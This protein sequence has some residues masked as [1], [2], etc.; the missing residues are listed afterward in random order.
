MRG[1]EGMERDMTVGKPGKIILNFTIPIFI[2]NIFQQLYSMVDTVIVGKFVGNEALAAVGSCGTLMFLILGFLMGLTAGFTVVTAQ[3]FGAGNMRAMRQSVASASVLSAVIS[4]L[5]T[6]LSMSFMKQILHLMHTPEDIYGEAY[7]YIMIICGGIVA[8]VLYNLLASILRALGNSKI[9]L[10]FL[11]LAA[12]LNIVLDLV[13]IIVFHL[14]AAG[15]AWATVI[16]QGISGILCL[17][18]IIKAVPELYLK[19]EDWHMNWN[20]A[21]W[22]MKIGLPMAFQYS[23]TAI[24]TIMVQT[25]L[26]TLGSLAVASFAA[27]TKI[28]QVVTQAYGAMGTTMATYCAQNTGA[29]K[30]DRVRQGFRSATIMGSIYAVVT[31]AVLILGGKYLTILFVKDNLTQVMGMVDIYLRCVSIMFIP[32]L[33]VNVYRNGIQG[34]GFGLLPMMAGIAELIGRGVMAI[35]SGKIG[36]YTGACMASPAAWILAGGLLLVMYFYIM[37]KYERQKAK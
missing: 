26:N 4:V 16:S 1:E 30:I 22:Q 19:R 10:Y 7:S 20:L 11:I 15:A 8:Q 34:M 3:H 36:S 23:I 9:P 6:V 21:G 29:K 31:G 27:A 33:V 18:Y 37:K 24:G 35:I 5:M 17:F 2:G 12:L 28:E 14:G 32:L 13:F 25:A